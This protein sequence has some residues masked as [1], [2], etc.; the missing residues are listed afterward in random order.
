MDFEDKVEWVARALAARVYRRGH[1]SATADHARA[2]ASGHW[3][4]FIRRALEV[5]AVQE[6][7]R[8]AREKALWN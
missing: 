4:R 6:A 7:W 8:Q 1:P 3:A 2:W 5:L